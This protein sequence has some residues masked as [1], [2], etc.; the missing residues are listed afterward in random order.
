MTIENAERMM[1]DAVATMGKILPDD[2]RGRDAVHVAVFSAVA[3][4]VL[5]PSQKVKIESH[6]GDDTV[7]GP[8][9]GDI[10]GIV[11]PFISDYV[12]P[13]ARFWV[14]L[15]PRTITGLTHQW[16]HTAFN[17]VRDESAASEQWLRSF[18]DVADCPG[19]DKVMGAVEYAADGGEYG[20][21]LGEDATGEIPPEFWDHAEVVLGKVIP[22]GVRSE[23]FRCAC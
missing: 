20:F 14:Y 12:M 11:D 16:T 2:A 10:I 13:G 7:V 21:V 15:L 19:Y 1:K 9:E 17:E 3:G 23:W 18:C 8:A 4:V 5:A 22:A 6:A